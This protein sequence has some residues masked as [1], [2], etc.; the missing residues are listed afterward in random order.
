[1][2]VPKESPKAKTLLNHK[3]YY[4]WF[5]LYKNITFFVLKHNCNQPLANNI[6]TVFAFRVSEIKMSQ[7]NILSN[8]E[9]KRKIDKGKRI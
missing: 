6:E 7:Q 2:Y 1:M 9:G 3:S 4:I 8:L 5:H